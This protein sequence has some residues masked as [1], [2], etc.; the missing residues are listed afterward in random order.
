MSRLHDTPTVDGDGVH[1]GA[2]GLAALLLLQAWVW[3]ASML[4]KL[5]SSSFL[6]GFGRFVSTAPPGRP[7]LYDHVLRSVVL[8]APSLF[9]WVALGTELG[10][11]LTFTVVAL[12]VLRPRRPLPRRLLVAVAL[13]SLV[14][15]GFAL[16]LALLVGD[17]APWTLHDPFDS[18]VAVEYLQAGLCAATAVVAISAVRRGSRPG[19]V[20]VAAGPGARAARALNRSTHREIT[21]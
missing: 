3:I 8:A 7:V 20:V 21:R 4:P 12:A 17:A 9:A 10:L 6:N 13:A 1:G 2:A 19:W 15:V 14:G 18:G 11:A 16:N 5:V